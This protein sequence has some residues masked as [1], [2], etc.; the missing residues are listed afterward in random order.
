MSAR[1][2]RYG[3]RGGRWID[4]DGTQPAA[5]IPCD[6]CGG[7]VHVGTRHVQCEPGPDIAAPSLFDEPSSPSE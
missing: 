7:A 4:G 2:I 5:P 1:D 6:V 3:R